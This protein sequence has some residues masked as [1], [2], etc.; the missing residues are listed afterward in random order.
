MIKEDKERR[1]EEI[2]KAREKERRKEEEKK[3]SDKDNN[4]RRVN[5]Q[6]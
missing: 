3:M 4:W 2:K 6:E 5:R 1:R